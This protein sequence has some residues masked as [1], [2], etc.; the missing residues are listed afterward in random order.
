MQTKDNPHIILHV[1]TLTHAVENSQLNTIQTITF[2]I[3]ITCDHEC[4]QSHCTAHL[5]F[6]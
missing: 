1:N 4:C 2:T 3:L 6:A 5:S